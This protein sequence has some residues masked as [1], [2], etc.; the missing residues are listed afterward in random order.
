ML[1]KILITFI[2]IIIA[3]FLFWSSFSLQGIFYEAVFSIEDYAY[4]NQI[5]VAVIFVV[6]AAFSAMLSPFSSV[7]FVPAV[8][9]L[10]GNFLTIGLLLAGWLIGAAG[11]Y[12]VGYFAGYPLVGQLYSLE[13]IK[14]FQE[15]ISHKTEFLIILLFRFAMPAEIPGYALGIVRYHFGKYLLATFIAELPFAII[16]AYASDALVNYRPAFFIGLVAFAFF[17][18][19]FMLYL[20]NKK[21][22][23]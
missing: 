10:W 14:Y 19:G 12:F 16:T 18:L 11:A 17:I 7:P 3:A 9:L 4:Q 5:L 21:L 15:R 23:K 2:L 20:F 8:I 1:Y 13:K 22:H 6:L